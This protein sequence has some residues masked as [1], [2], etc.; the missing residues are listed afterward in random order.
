MTNITIINDEKPNECR[1]ILLAAMAFSFPDYKNMLKNIEKIDAFHSNGRKRS[2]AI[3]ENEAVGFVDWT[4]SEVNWLMVLPKHHRSKIGTRLIN[5]VKT[6]SDKPIKTLCV[7]TNFSALQFYLK[8]GFEILSN[9]A[10][11]RMFG[12]YFNNFR[13]IYR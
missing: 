5:V 12:E 8:S 11:G 9:D 4:S 3:Y 7:D 6:N 13:L 1:D 2:I 10:Q